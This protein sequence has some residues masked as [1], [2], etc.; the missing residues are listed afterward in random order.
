[1]Q[2][3]L[4]NLDDAET[5]ELT[6][7]VT[8]RDELIMF[9]PRQLLLTIDGQMFQPKGV[10]MNN[11]DRERQV[12]D[13]FVT[14][15]RQA[16]PNQPPVTPRA[17]DWREA[18]HNPVTLRPMEQSPGFI[19]IFPLPLL[20]PERDLAPNINRALLEPRSPERPLIH[21]KSMPWS[22]GYS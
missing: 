18:V 20:S 11:H 12:I 3:A 4:A 9:D 16:P 15:R 6:V 5:L 13:N 19:V 2:A 1:V 21:F 8:A 14:A 17:S 10:W 7:Q 22:Q